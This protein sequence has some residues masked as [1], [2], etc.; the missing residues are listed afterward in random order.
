L[1][2]GWHSQQSKWDSGD[3]AYC[4]PGDGMVYLSGS[5]AQSSGT[6]PEFA[7]LPRSGRPASTIFLSSYASGGTIGSVKIDIHGRMFAQLDAARDFTSLAGISFPTAA[8]AAAGHQITPLLNTW[9]SGQNK[10]RTGNPSYVVRH[11]I[12]HLSGSVVY[13]SG[14]PAAGSSQWIFARL[15]RV[16]RPAGCFGKNVYTYNGATA[17][18]L[19]DPVNGHIYGADANFTSLAAISY[20]AAPLTWHQ[21]PRRA[22]NDL[23]A[24]KPPSYYISQGVV[25]L[26]GM[27]QM[28][29]TAVF[30]VLPPAARP[31]HALFF[32]V[33]GTGSADE[34]NTV[35]RI[36]PDGQMY[37]FDSTSSS[38]FF[39]LAGLSYHIGS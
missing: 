34:V 5:L 21:L 10:Y 37:A 6:D 32:N 33:D 19:I 2:N 18:V 4:I 14:V 30:A 11:G 17:P 23:G 9:T 31:K 38:Y 27:L 28:S 16:A 15:P 22:G 7:V 20:P 24:C 39:S 8:T 26:T 29:Q 12:V 35:L 1:V 13:G 36:S 25:Y 3:P